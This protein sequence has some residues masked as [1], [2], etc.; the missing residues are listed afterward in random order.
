MVLK[1]REKGGDEYIMKGDFDDATS[2][3]KTRGSIL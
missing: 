3:P 2:G 1:N